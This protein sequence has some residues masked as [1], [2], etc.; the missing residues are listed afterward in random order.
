M[1]KQHDDYMKQLKLL[2]NKTSKQTQ[3][4]LQDIFNSFNITFN[5]LYNI[6]DI[7][8]KGRVNSYIEEMKDK[9][10]LTGYF[11]M[12]ANNIYRRTRV[13][14]SEILELLIYGAYIEEQSKLEETELNI[15]KEDA[16]Y[17]YQQGQEEVNKILKKK[18]IVSV[19]PDAIFL[20]LLDTPNVKGW[21]YNEY[22]QTILK[23]N[24]EQIYRQYIIDLQQQKEPDI[25]DDIYQNIIKRQ[26]NSRLCI[27]GDKISG[28]VDLTLIG[29]N[30]LAKVE[31]IKSITDDNAQVIFLANI[32]GKETEMCHSLNNQEFYINEENEFNR[33]YG[34]TQKDLIIRRIK[35]DGLVLGLNLP[36][37]SHHFHY[38][39]SMIQYIPPKINKENDAEGNLKK[40]LRSALNKNLFNYNTKNI[41]KIAL[42]QN[43]IN[44]KKVIKDFPVLNNKIRNIKIRNNKDYSMAIKPLSNASG[45]NLYINKDVFKTIKSARQE[46]E[47]L[48]KLGEA[49]KGTSYKDILMHELGH[50]VTYEIIKKKYNGDLSLIDNDWCNSIT[51]TEIVNKSLK[52]IG[53]T[54]Y[55]DKYKTI[56]NLSTYALDNASETIG[57]AFI[58]FYSNGSKSQKISKEIIKVMK[59]MI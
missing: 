5:N 1:W 7:K 19:I 28:E 47:K 45:F 51:S 49:P 36:P 18:K 46:Y 21:T 34:E 10:L 3:N 44:G 2:Y 12:L 42:I 32:D 58:D 38:C 17:Y 57:E 22:I 39:R 54:D 14:N 53:V 29:L 15:F 30:N 41:S 24:A 50:G 20:A 27:N 37:I 52:N 9:G 48:I 26:Q 16:N 31:G 6:V 11:G 23:Y 8:T 4:R 56:S 33:Y 55:K 40:R 13:K 59:G 35:C 43:L 25:T